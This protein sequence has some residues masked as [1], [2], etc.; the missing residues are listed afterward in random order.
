MKINKE[1]NLVQL[2]QELNGKGL[3]ATFDENQK[4]IEVTLADNN[5]IPVFASAEQETK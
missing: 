2:D 4:I 5:T 1:I 3:N